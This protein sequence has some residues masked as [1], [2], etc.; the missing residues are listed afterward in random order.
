MSS[1]TYDID[2][3]MMVNFG[4]EATS[5]GNDRRTIPRIKLRPEAH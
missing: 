4:G 3:H 5:M 2:V 1:T